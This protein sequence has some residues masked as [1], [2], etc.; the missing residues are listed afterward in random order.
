MELMKKGPKRICENVY[1]VGSFTRSSKLDSSV[2]AVIGDGGTAL[3]D[4][5][6]PFG[7]ESLIKNLDSIGVD[8]SD[9]R[10]VFGT[11]CHYDHLAGYAEL[12]RRNPKL[13]LAVHEDD[14]A[15]VE[16]GDPIATCAG[17]MFK[18]IFEGALVDESLTDGSIIGVAGIEFEII[19]VPGHS[20]GSIAVIA[21]VHGERIAFIGDS[22]IPSCGRAG[23]NFDALSDSWEILL[24]LNADIV[25]PGHESH[26]IMNPFVQVASQGISPGFFTP[27]FGFKPLTKPLA[28]LHSFL[29][30]N[31]GIMVGL[32]KT[33][34]NFGK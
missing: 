9:V 28:E 29:Y 30:S 31:N 12:K 34:E 24:N 8:L 33:L 11:H 13:M 4:C 14:R 27:V 18:E 32:A 15:A 16:E 6:S 19:S 25:C 1:L 7:T 17:W 26:E 22:F 3:I 5:G 20:P 23:Y 10:I 21:D 2:Y